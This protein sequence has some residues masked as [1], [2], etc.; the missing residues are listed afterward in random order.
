MNKD[1]KVNL[2]QISESLLQVI[3]LMNEQEVLIKVL[4]Q[5]LLK[6]EAIEKIWNKYF[7]FLHNEEM[8]YEFE[9]KMIEIFNPS[10]ELN[11]E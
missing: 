9:D 2:Q 10:K 1:K 7:G 6:I 3:G 4:E 11:D 8:R 5:R